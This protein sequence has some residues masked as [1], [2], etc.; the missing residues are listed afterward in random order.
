MFTKE[1]LDT[2]HSDGAIRVK[3][4][5]SGY[6]VEQLLKGI[7]R[8][9]RHPGPLFK[10]DIDADTG[11]YMF[12]MWTRK[13]IPEFQAFLH[14]SELAAM[15]AQCLGE[16]QARL[17]LDAWFSKPAGTVERTPWHQDIGILGTYY[18]FWVALDPIPKTESLE[19]VKGSHL[20]DSCFMFEQYFTTE[21]G[22]ETLR[23]M[24]E[25]CR[26]YHGRGEAQSDAAGRLTFKQIPDIENARG[27]YEILSWAVEPGDCIVFHGMMLH[28]SSGNPSSA[29]AR[30]F[31]SRWAEPTAVV[32][33]HGDVLKGAVEAT[34]HDVPLE[35]GT[36]FGGEMF[37]LLPEKAA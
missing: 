3:N 22:A 31:V 11:G 26:A 34:G 23:E 21:K 4:A 29:D 12:D 28:S 1:Q 6:W 37:P 24:Q 25:A 30:R 18:S 5:F 32:G 27:D 2:L 19:L 33:P 20:W 13:D 36:A 17:M 35:L 8:N 9:I 10:G 14:E 7:E 16:P 15:A